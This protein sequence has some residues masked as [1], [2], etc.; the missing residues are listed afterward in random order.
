MTKKIS[1]F[2][3][4]DEHKAMLKKRAEEEGRSLTGHLEVLIKQD[5][6]GNTTVTIPVVE[7]RAYEEYLR[8]FPAHDPRD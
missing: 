7:Q 4:S 5:F 8:N 3:L 1:T 6:S 2:S